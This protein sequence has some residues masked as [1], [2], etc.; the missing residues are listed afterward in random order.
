MTRIGASQCASVE[1]PAFQVLALERSLVGKHLL[2]DFAAVF[3]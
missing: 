2:L 3:R 1:I